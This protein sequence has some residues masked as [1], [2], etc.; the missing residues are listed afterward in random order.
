MALGR[1][2][3]P[4]N[5]ARPHVAMAVRT[6]SPGNNPSGGAEARGIDIHRGMDIKWTKG[7]LLLG[8]NLNEDTKGLPTFTLADTDSTMRT[9]IEHIHKF[10][11]KR[12]NKEHP[13]QSDK[14]DNNV[15]TCVRLIVKGFN[16][17]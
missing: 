6:F 16:E 8:T 13:S 7:C 1:V 4:T 15:L 17:L 12:Y 3:P 5:S 11:G 14:F 9:F 10:E 2:E